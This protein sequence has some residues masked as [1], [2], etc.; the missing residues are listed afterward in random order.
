MK[1][2]EFDY[3][4]PEGLVAQVPAPRRDASRML[5]LERDTATVTHR[6]FRELPD[7]LAPGDLLVVNDTRV[8]SARLWGR[9]PSGGRVEMLVVAPAL[10]PSSSSWPNDRITLRVGWNPSA[11]SASH[12]SRSPNTFRSTGSFQVFCL[13]LK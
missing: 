10:L 13:E 11:S 2:D 9:K 4:L 3:G 7:L 12:A 1:V 8:R 5:V 6:R